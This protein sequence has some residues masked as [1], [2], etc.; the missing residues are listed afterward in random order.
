MGSL[1]TRLESGYA[2]DAS[3]VTTT[4]IGDR[5]GSE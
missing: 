3:E 1:A 4:R 5:F 2:Y